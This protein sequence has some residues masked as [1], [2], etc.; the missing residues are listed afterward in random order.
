MDITFIDI[1][2]M[3]PEWILKVAENLKTFL[4]TY[5][6]IGGVRIYVFEILTATALALWLIA[7]I[8]KAIL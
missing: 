1:L 7:T 2:F 5:A 6:E 8:I 3:L 4:F